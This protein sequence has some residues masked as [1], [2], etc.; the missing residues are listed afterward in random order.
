MR[1]VK[2]DEFDSIKGYLEKH[3]PKNPTLFFLKVS[4]LMDRSIAT[5]HRIDASKDY[6]AYTKLVR[7][8]HTAKNPRTPLH[9]QLHEARIN[10]LVAIRSKGRLG[11]YKHACQRLDELTA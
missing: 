2:Q 5:I 3:K 9:V 8:E 1:S 11:A 7:S 10:E 6:K 4:K